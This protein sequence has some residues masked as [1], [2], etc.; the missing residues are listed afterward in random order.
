ME[1]DREGFLQPV[2]NAKV[3]LKCHRCER[4]C[5]ILNPEKKNEEHQTDAFAAINK[6]D[7]IRRK[8]SSGGV[9]YAL[10]KWTIEQGGVVFGARFNEQW[11]VVHDFSETRDGIIPFLGSK[12]VQSFIGETYKQAKQ[13]LE[14]GRWVLFTGTPCQLGGLRSF[15]GKDYDRLLQVDIICY[16]VPSPGVWR[17]YLKEL[18]REK[19][20][21]S[22]ISFRDKQDGWKHFRF[23]I[24]FKKNQAEECNGLF[25]KGFSYKAYL[26]R[27]CYECPFRKYHRNT[28]ITIADYWGVDKYCKEMFDDKG[29]SIVFAH[30]P[31]GDSVIA[32]ISDSV[33][34]VSESRENA[35]ANNPYM[36]MNHS[37]TDKRDRFFRLYHFTS[38]FKKSSFVIN[39]DGIKIRTIRK[40]KKILNRFHLK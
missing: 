37:W 14:D 26:R 16:G 23:V 3:C 19:G 40:I 22:S 15:L 5:P 25:M 38:S 8:S 18:T 10:A 33:K 9:F 7:T 13:F 31:K 17:T 24:D 30:S 6:D 2:I 34:F 32:T 12:Y 11:R 20:E 39:K 4:V 1:E 28:D 36:I 27:S 29:T 35:T 21:I